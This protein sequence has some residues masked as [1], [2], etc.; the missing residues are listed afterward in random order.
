[1]FLPFM[2]LPI[3]QPTISAEISIEYLRPV[4][5]KSLDRGKWSGIW[6]EE[7]QKRNTFC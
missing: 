2:V 4:R 1:M 7:S 5:N 6:R 3:L